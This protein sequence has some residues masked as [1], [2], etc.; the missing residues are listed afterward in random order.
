MFIVIVITIICLQAILLTF[1]GTAF[2]VYPYY[3]LHP[4]HWAISVPNILL[5][6]DWLRFN[7]FACQ[8]AT[9]VYPFIHFPRKG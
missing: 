9:Q 8:F 5:F 4:L 3:G 1:A 6:L 2:G 7:I